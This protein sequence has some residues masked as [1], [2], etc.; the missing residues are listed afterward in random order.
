MANVHELP[1][2]PD[3][4]CMA[5]LLHSIFQQSFHG[6]VEIAWI[7]KSGA[8]GARLFDLTELDEAAAWAARANANAGQNVYFSA[9]L[10]SYEAETNERAKKTDVISVAAIKVD[11]DDPGCLTRAL[12]AAADGG[13]P[14]NIAI[15]TSKEPSLRGSLWWILDEPGDQHRAE[16]IEQRLIA[17]FGADKSAW[18]C[19][20]IMKLAG[21]VAWPTKKDR[22]IEVTGHYEAVTRRQPYTLD[23][24][25]HSIGR[26][27]IGKTNIADRVVEIELNDAK[28]TIDVAE[29]LE[30]ARAPEKF[31]EFALPAI[32]S[33]VRKGVPPEPIIELLGGAIALA[34]V[35]PKQ[36][37]REMVN[38]VR[39][40]VQKVVPAAPTPQPD[41]IPATPEGRDPFPL[42]ALDEI[43]MHGPPEWRIEG[44]IPKRGFGVLYGPSGAFKSFVALDMALTVAHGL[45]W[46]GKPVEGAGAAYIAGE[47]TYG[48]QNRVLAW[49]NSRGQSSA[50]N[51][52]F[53]LAPVAANFL[54]A[55]TVKLIAERLAALP[56]RVG[57][58]VVDTLARSFGGGNEKES[59][60]M[61]RFVAACDYIGAACNAFVLAI[62]H[63]GKDEA[64][65]ARGSNVLKAAAD[66]EISITRGIGESSAVLKVTKMKDSEDGARIRVRM[67]P[68]EGVFPATGEVVTSLVPVIETEDAAKPS[69]RIGKL[70]RAVLSV[71]E[72][73]PANFGTIQKRLD[74][75]KGSLGRALRGLLEKNYC[76]Q[77]GNLW[78]LAGG[79]SESDTESDD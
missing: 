19:D 67:V 23:E 26:A 10:R 72:D 24:I 20:R 42:I 64:R 75:D 36:R 74:A 54:D 38:M 8:I 57:F 28:R 52:P 1:V 51:K 62:H 16:R 31:H 15:F 11:C 53:W 60:D 21:S 30:A 33:L 66:V 79:V 17:M 6:R 59:V 32:M 22:V 5:G 29:F 13:F 47:G 70:E 37:H 41:A 68:V 55:P 25:E 34:G 63:T 12:N 56:E 77:D 18:N 45:D 58:V 78:S 76:V 14:P 73:G 44:L 65:G 48:I 9:G 46:R 50:P 7:A 39:G 2:Q 71:L 49:R 40:A 69:G 3:E 61:G 43:G 4:D 35:N 27:Q